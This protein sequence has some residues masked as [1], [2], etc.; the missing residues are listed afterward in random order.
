MPECAVC[1]DSDAAPV[2]VPVVPAV[3]HFCSFPI[4]AL[5]LLKA[6]AGDESSV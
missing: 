3:A 4:L 5:G 1:V 6:R 2:S